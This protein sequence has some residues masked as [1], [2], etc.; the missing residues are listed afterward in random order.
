MAEEGPW[1]K[2]WVLYRACVRMPIAGVPKA[3]LLVLVGFAN[4]RGCAWPGIDTLVTCSGWGRTAVIDA[5]QSLEALGVVVAERRTGR[6]TL[7]WL[8]PEAYAG[9]GTPAIE[10]DPSVDADQDADSEHADQSAKRTSPP[11]GPVRQTDPT[12]PPDGPDPSARRTRS[13][14][15][16][17]RTT[18][19]PLPPEGGARSAVV[20]PEPGFAAFMAAYP[21][22]A[23]EARARRQWMRMR[24]DTHLQ[25]AML[26]ALA[27]Q[28][29]SAEWQRE[30]GRYIPLPGKWLRGQRWLDGSQA[31][32]QRAARPANWVDDPAQV[33]DVGAS[34]G[35]PYSLSA[36]GNGYTDD[37]RIAHYRR[38]RAAVIEAAKAEVPA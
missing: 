35:M 29:Q 30:G 24:P 31:Q 3:V 32:Q 18:N 14:K 11:N 6:S 36:L 7:Y 17:Q 9:A 5:I 13:P 28:R 2:P 12:S 19:T 20:D 37:Q 21:R 4:K 22:K 8:R 38:Y 1:A 10:G 23:A 15:N 16:Y 26:A 33:K 27:M 34:L 25:T